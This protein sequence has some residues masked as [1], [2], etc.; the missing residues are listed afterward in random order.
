M[1]PLPASFWSS[2]QHAT[3]VPG[4]ITT[5]LGI[6]ESE[7]PPR[8]A[9]GRARPRHRC[10]DHSRGPGRDPLSPQVDF[11]ENRVRSRAR[12]SD[13]ST[14][15]PDTADAGSDPYSSGS[16]DRLGF[17]RRD[18]VSGLGTPGV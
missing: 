5:T 12:A 14:D 11:L 17:H 16:R 9:P 2:A 15:D 7:S 18:V 8:V 6:V 10:H 4:S 1:A 13:L 3:L